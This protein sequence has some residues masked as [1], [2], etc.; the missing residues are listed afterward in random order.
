MHLG[1][2]MA[3]TEEAGGARVPPASALAHFLELF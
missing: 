3:K 2:A 1:K